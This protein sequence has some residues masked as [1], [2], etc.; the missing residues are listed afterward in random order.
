[1]D[2]NTTPVPEEKMCWWTRPKRGR[3]KK[4]ETPE[5]RFQKETKEYSDAKQM[6]VW[7]T[8]RRFADEYTEALE[9]LGIK[10]KIDRLTKYGP[11]SFFV[12][13]LQQLK[14]PEI[15]ARLSEE[16]KKLADRMGPVYF[17]RKVIEFITSSNHPK[18]QDMK[19]E[20]A[21]RSSKKSWDKF[22]DDGRRKGYGITFWYVEAT[23]LFL[24]I[25]ILLVMIS[26]MKDSPY[27]LE[28]FSSLDGS[29][30]RKDLEVG[31]ITLCEKNS[32]HYQSILVQNGCE[33]L[34][35]EDFED[36]EK[37]LYLELKQE[38][39][40]ICPNCRNSYKRLLT[41]ISMPKSSCNGKVSEEFLKK[42][43]D[44]AAE[45]HKNNK[46]KSKRRIQTHETHKARIDRL[47]MHSFYMERH[48]NKKRTFQKKQRKEEKVEEKQAETEI[49]KKPRKSV[50]K[51]IEDALAKRRTLERDGD[52]YQDENSQ[53]REQS[54]M[55]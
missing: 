23:A 14:H 7:K 49:Q 16:N 43:K 30:Q 46:S 48:R 13:T 40:Y 45:Q 29:Q 37:N 24:N 6:K 15:Y 21:K 1:M 10:Y 54:M 20:F 17:K 28:S 52:E 9:K 47:A 25:E 34:K 36:Y 11:N 31:P 32:F 44:R 50:A 38:A 41:H 8:E 51:I 5:M 26:D 22:W 3:K 39:E 12:A 55:D 19:K 33:K 2:N 35:K 18:V 4:K 42:L 27:F 53:D